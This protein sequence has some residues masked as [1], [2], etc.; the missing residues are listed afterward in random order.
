MT[1]PTLSTYVQTTI[2][3]QIASEKVSPNFTGTPTAS[4]P[5]TDTSSN[6]I[7]TCD[8][9]Q[10]V[11]YELAN[12]GTLVRPRINDLS[13]NYQYIFQPSGLTDN[14]I[15][16]LPLLTTHD[17]FV[18]KDH[19]QTLTNKTL[20]APA[21]G[22]PAS[23]D[24]S[25]CTN[26]PAGSI[27]AGTMSD[28]TLVAPALGIPASGDL[29]NCTFPTLNQSTTGT[30][31]TVT[32]PAQPTITS[33]G[34]LAGG[35]IASGFGTISSGDTITSTAAVTG[36][37]LIT[38]SG[39]A[40]G[41]LESNGDYD[42][43]LQTGNST[44][45]SITIAD[46]ADG[47]INIDPNGLGVVNVYGKLT[48]SDTI[49]GNVTG[50]VTGDLSGSTGVDVNITAASD[51]FVVIEGLKFT[52]RSIT[53]ATTI[54]A[55]TFNG[56]LEGNASTATQ[57]N[58][59]TNTDIVQ[60]LATQELENKTFVAPVLGIP[61]SGDLSNCTFPTLNQ[62]TTGTALTVTQAAQTYITTLNNLT[63][64]GTSDTATTFSGP[65][66]FEQGI[67]KGTVDSS[68]D[69]SYNYS[70]I[71]HTFKFIDGLAGG[72]TAS[73]ITVESDKVL[74]TSAVLSSSNKNVDVR[75]HT[76]VTG[77][78]K[79]SIKNFEGAFEPNSDIILNYVVL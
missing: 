43:I 72:D 56:N 21:L 76:V 75:I 58:G 68:G 48:V 55:T 30:A 40:N 77:S 69:I 23:G 3:D 59:I 5:D 60:K 18:F 8:F 45:G 35:S 37:S 73:D 14:I 71:S 6:Q 78:F 46:G 61:E 9:V 67:D 64:V 44:T 28:M 7:A 20:T 25:N 52:L 41:V 79:V 39:S 38:G 16:T 36:G 66:T 1:K 49:I 17:E 11:A 29:S 70:G 24:L 51:Q 12:D 32:T 13:G 47:D 74:A 15:V 27:T 2:V 31:A 62:S 53:N 26:L 57:I 42:L 10:N 65:I 33:V 19:I 4:T 54:N 63:A 50:N 34:A 22:T